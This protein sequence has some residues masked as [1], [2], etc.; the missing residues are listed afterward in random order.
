MSQEEKMID[1]ERLKAVQE[2]LDKRFPDKFLLSVGDIASFS[3]ASTKTVYKWTAAKSG[4]KAPFP[5]KHIGR[6]P[7]VTKYDFA[8]YLAGV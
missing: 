6:I 5:I 4:V 3:G 1:E 8:R 2:E 7:K